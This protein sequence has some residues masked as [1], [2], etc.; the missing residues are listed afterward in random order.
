MRKITYSLVLLLAV[1]LYG[2]GN[3]ITI[4]FN[5]APP[6]GPNQCSFI[7]LGNDIQTNPGVFYFCDGS[8]GTWTALGAGGAGTV[9]S[10]S[11]TG[12]IVSIATATTTP[13]FT[14]A[15]TSG[16]IPYFSGATTWASSGAL[17][18]N[19]PVIGG[20]AGG[21]P[22]VGTRSG[23]TTAFVTTTGTQTS[24][25]CVSID[26]NGNHIAS[27]VAGCSGA[28]S[29]V[30][31]RT[32]AVTA[33]AA[34]YGLGLIGNPAATTSFSYALNQG[35]TWTFSGS[36]RF[37][38]QGTPLQLGAAAAGTGQVDFF[39]TT[40]GSASVSVADTAGTPNK[41][42]LPT[43]T[44]GAGTVL[45]S[46]GGNPQQ[47]SWIAAGSGDVTDV[48]DCSSGAC[49]VSGGTGGLLFFAQ[50]A[51]PGSPA[52]GN[53]NV[54][55][56]STDARL[57][58]KNPAGTIGT[59][60]VADAGTAN[61]WFSAMSAA[62]VFTK[63]QPAFTNISGSL[64]STQLTGTSGGVPYFSAANTY[65][66]S[67]ALTANMPVIGGGAGV[68]PSVGTVSGNTTAFVTTTGTQTSGDCVKIDANGNHIAN[69]SACGGGSSGSYFF[70][71][72][73]FGLA[74]SSAGKGVASANQIQTL[75]VNI[76]MALSIT[77]ITFEIQ[78]TQA[79]TSFSCGL[80]N[81]AGTLVLSTGAVSV[82]SG[83]TKTTT[84]GAT[85]VPAG[86]YYFAS[87][88]DGTT[89]K[90]YGYSNAYFSVQIKGGI[91]A[92]A[93]SG[94]ALPASITVPTGILTSAL[95]FPMCSF[96]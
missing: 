49:F 32:G 57:H 91:S 88:F 55:V 7:M 23:N 56:D 12:G 82:A 66:S 64:G 2:Q 39:G 50:T 21:A 54:W 79:S 46:D 80:Y 19:L 44:G 4:P 34:D 71:G 53:Q 83:T 61:Q 25:D 93:S 69:G 62:G 65:G 94:G 8:T 86:V 52:A 81:S 16:G 45:S 59:T 85:A 31:G 1:G 87:T 14:I 28:V 84:I 47:L 77:T 20:G 96:R 33:Q 74:V 76:P 37:L 35:G 6:A 78:T 72:L 89:A 48:G 90:V 68:A 51:A 75:E 29:S 5:G 70:P 40:S 63:S 15:G 42:L 13:A 58:D 38:I 24:G 3:T 9:T 27:G 11:W 26:A 17:T 10:V 92:T 95:N 60:V 30:F 73:M 43:A 22:S 18:A 41:I 67:G 36:G